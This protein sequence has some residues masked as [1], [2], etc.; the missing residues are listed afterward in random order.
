MENGSDYCKT[1]KGTGNDRSERIGTVRNKG[2]M[3]RTTT[4]GI[5]T[6]AGTGM[7]AGIL[8]QWITTLK[9]YKS[10]VAQWC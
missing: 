1:I 2:A 10:L 9:F 5:L 4:D 6:T 3:S 8:R 7:T